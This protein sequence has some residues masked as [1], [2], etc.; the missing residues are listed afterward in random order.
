VPLAVQIRTVVVCSSRIRASTT[1]WRSADPSSDIGSRTSDA[2][3]EG[4]RCF[5]T[6][7]AATL[8]AAFTPLSRPV[9]FRNQAPTG[10]QPDSTRTPAHTIGRPT[11][12]CLLD[13][14][15]SSSGTV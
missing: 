12:S 9:D 11:E 14:T 7:A 4:A 2:V 3:S 10:R 8:F 13:A 15:R 6:V 1:R 5:L